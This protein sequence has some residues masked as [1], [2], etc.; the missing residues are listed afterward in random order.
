MKT[1]IF[2]GVAVFCVA[3]CVT[4]TAFG[5]KST[6][7]YAKNIAQDDA[8]QSAAYREAL[9]ALKKAEQEFAKQEAMADKEKVAAKKTEENDIFV[10]YFNSTTDNQPD[11]SFEKD[12]AP[13]IGEFKPNAYW[14]SLEALKLADMNFK[15]VCVTLGVESDYTGLLDIENNK[16]SEKAQ[17]YSSSSS[18]KRLAI[19]QVPQ[20]RDYW[21][22]YAAMKSLLDFEGVN[23]TQE[24]I[25]NMVS[26][27]NSSCPWYTID[28]TTLSQYPV[29]KVL[30]E[31]TGFYYIA[32]PLNS[33][34]ATVL[35]ESDIKPKVVFTI[36][37]GHGLLACGQSYRRYDREGSRLPG[38]PEYIV[39]H[40][41]AIDGYQS[42]GSE[43]WIV[44]PAKSPVVSWSDSISKYYLVSA[45]KLAS[46]A[47]MRG[48][49]Y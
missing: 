29:P 30:R 27:P 14:E 11:V 42:D 38:Y 49:V 1:K 15:D 2:A 34:G 24:E 22:G 48:I 33:A 5:A 31:L 40:W 28:G 16:V 44:D 47:T 19:F 43:V 41:V 13:V 21:C 36:D 32:F 39:T 20:E 4:V 18:A 26:S 37:H 17:P 35:T 12:Y 45:E 25:A 3:T 46:F 9:N 6:N 8:Y 7:L 23:M 10:N